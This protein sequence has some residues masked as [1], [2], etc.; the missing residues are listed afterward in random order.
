VAKGLATGRNKQR[1]RLRVHLQVQ[2]IEG[3]V[4]TTQI[5]NPPKK[6]RAVQGHTLG[7]SRVF[8][9]A[10]VIRPDKLAFES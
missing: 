7:N 8:E 4:D 3:N 9:P 5:P 10:A 1:L 6:R 2:R